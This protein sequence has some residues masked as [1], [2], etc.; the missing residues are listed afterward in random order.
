MSTIVA[1][2]GPAARDD[3]GTPHQELLTPRQLTAAARLP[4]GHEVVGVRGRTPIV[5]RPDG[6]LSRMMSSGRLVTTGDVQALQSYLLV[7]G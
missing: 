2:T 4:A 1:I 6:R 3:G 7:S 5:R